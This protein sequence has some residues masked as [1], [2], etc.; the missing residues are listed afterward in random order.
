MHVHGA[1]A[2]S[3]AEGPETDQAIRRGGH[4]LRAFVHK[5]GRQDGR[6]VS[7]EGA[8]LRVVRHRPQL[9]RPVARARHQDFVDGGKHYFPDASF[10]AH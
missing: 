5:L 6:S 1:L 4:Q 3:G 10:V 8:Q 9:H 7:I 2:F